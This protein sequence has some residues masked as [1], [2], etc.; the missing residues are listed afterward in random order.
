MYRGFVEKREFFIFVLVLFLVF[1][2]GGR[3]EFIGLLLSIVLV[4]FFVFFVSFL[5]RFSISRMNIYFVFLA[6]FI[7]LFGF[8]LVD[9]LPG[10]LNNRN[11]Q[12]FDLDNASS[13]IARNEIMSINMMYIRENLL[14]GDFGSHFEMG[15]GAYIHNILSIWQQFG[16]L[17]FMLYA[18]IIFIPVIYFGFMYFKSEDKV[19]LNPLLISLYVAI[20]LAATKSFFWPVAGLFVD[21]S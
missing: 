4:L 6:I 8:V 1:V 16:G 21:V 2:T 17:V 7:V 12:I 3:S 10:F 15:R 9:Y 20:L 18:L 13:V 5:K 11:F 14:L 19:Y